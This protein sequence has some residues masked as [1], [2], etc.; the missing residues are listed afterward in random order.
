MFQKAKSMSHCGA[1]GGRASRVCLG[2]GGSHSASN[3]ACH[4]CT[5]LPLDA[6][7]SRF[8]QA[9]SLDSGLIE[10]FLSPET[11]VSLSDDRIVSADKKILRK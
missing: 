2:H 8:Q 11:T 1:G 5:M 9:A 3:A 4:M 7:C 10:Q 6:A